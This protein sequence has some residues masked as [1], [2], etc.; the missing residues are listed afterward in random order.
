[1]VQTENLSTK[2]GIKMKKRVAS[3]ALALSMA[4]SFTCQSGAA[5]AADTDAADQTQ[6]SAVK[7]VLLDAG[8]QEKQIT[9]DRDYINK[10]KSL[11]GKR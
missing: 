4:L 5:E 9:Q 6:R 8:M 1:M 2:E 3:L 10:A 7:S 11:A